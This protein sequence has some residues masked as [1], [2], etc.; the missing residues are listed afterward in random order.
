MISTNENE[1]KE[2]IKKIKDANYKV[3]SLTN[4]LNKY[5]RNKELLEC[6]VSPGAVDT[7][8]ILVDGGKHCNPLEIYVLK[9]DL[10]IWK[11]LDK[12]IKI[13]QEE[14]KIEMDWIDNKLK[15]LNKYG[16]L[17]QQIIYYKEIDI[18]EYTWYQIAAKVHYSKDYCRR[19][20]RNYNKKRNI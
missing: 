15:S 2:D 8:K 14:I 18:K 16:K 11:D 10:S 12:K 19:I 17:V 7:T 20:Y 1:V 13:I 5:L 9:Q 6:M 4:D 3:E